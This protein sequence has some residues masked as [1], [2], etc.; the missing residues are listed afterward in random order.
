MPVVK[1]HTK[2]TPHSSVERTVEDWRGDKKPERKGPWAVH[3]VTHGQRLFVPSF[4][5]AKECFTLSS[6]CTVCQAYGRRCVHCPCDLE[7]WRIDPTAGFTP[8]LG[9]VAGQAVC[10][11]HRY[12]PVPE[13][14]DY[15]EVRDVVLDKAV[16]EI[17]LGSAF[18][19]RKV[20]TISYQTGDKQYWVNSHLAPQ[21]MSQVSATDYL[22]ALEFGCHVLGFLND[23][24]APA[25]ADIH[26]PY[27]FETWDVIDKRWAEE[28]KRRKT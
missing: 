18:T 3:C 22:S 15:L 25:K 9:R 13:A 8:S 26:N 5:E 14:I 7:Q 4:A 23:A 2:R 19:G 12:G 24:L 28:A 11:Y 27:A 16:V 1:S 10:R 17:S 6:S 21:F 20:F